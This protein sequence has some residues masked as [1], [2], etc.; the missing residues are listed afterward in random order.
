MSKSTIMAVATMTAIESGQTIDQ[1]KKMLNIIDN[2]WFR[3]SSKA[4]QSVF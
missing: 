1:I 4:H 2:D 3:F